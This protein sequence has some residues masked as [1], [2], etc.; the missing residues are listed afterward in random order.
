MTS[1]ALNERGRI[2]AR[3]SAAVQEKIQ[4]AADIMGATLNQ[5]LIQ[6]SLER[7]DQVIERER[8]ITLSKR[9]AAM[10]SD[11]LDKPLAPNKALTK[12]LQLY[13]TKIANG[14]LHTSAQPKP[15]ASA[16]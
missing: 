6:A 2:S 3:V 13:K 5:F 4:D 9:D 1:I 16:V 12:A 10:L 15:P 7:A 8:L 11:L 14:T